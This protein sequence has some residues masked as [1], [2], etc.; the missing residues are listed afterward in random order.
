M[1]GY[2]TKIE[3]G[4]ITFIVQTQDKGKPQNCVESLI[5]KSGRALAPRKTFYTQHLSHPDLPAKIQQ[6][7]EDQHRIVLQAISE[8]KF[9][10]L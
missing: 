8:G 7:I 10:N 6:I 9:D 3:K 5:Y 2:N 1:A 4:G